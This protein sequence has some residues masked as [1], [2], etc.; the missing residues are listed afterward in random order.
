MTPLPLDVVPPLLLPDGP[1]LLLP[2]P[3]TPPLLLPLPP[4]LPPDDPL[5]PEEPP[6]DDPPSPS[7]WFIVFVPCAPETLPPHAAA[8]AAT[9]TSGAQK[10]EVSRRVCFIMVLRSRRAQGR[11][12]Q[13]RDDIV[14]RGCAKFD[15]AG[16]CAAASFRACCRLL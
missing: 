10:G 5:L 15:P 11:A 12:S 8:A 6:L 2:L 4:L 9:R 3:D 7:F 16:T 1:P 13:G 14:H